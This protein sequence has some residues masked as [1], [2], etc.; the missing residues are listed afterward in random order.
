[1]A[2]WPGNRPDDSVELFFAAVDRGDAVRLLGRRYRTD[3]GAAATDRPR[4][5]GSSSSISTPRRAIWRGCA[6]RAPRG[7]SRRR[8]RIGGR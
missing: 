2:T 7:W 6:T 4:A 5:R 8:Y 1:M 3:D